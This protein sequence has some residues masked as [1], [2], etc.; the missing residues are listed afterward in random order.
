MI[1]VTTFRDQARTW[2]AAT[3]P[4]LENGLDPFDSMTE[5][6]A[7]R[8]AKWLQHTLFDGGFAGIVFP[9]EYGGRGLTPAH[10]QAFTAEANGYQSP[11]RFNMSTVAIIAPAILEFGTEEQKRRWLPEILRGDTF[12]AQLLSE[13]TG[14][15]DLAGARTRATRDGDLWI[16]NGSKVWTTGG[17]LRDM[18]LCLARTDW[19]VPKHKGLSFFAV[20]LHEPGVEVRRI[21]Q[22]DGNAD[23]CQEFFTDVALPADRLVG[24]PGQGWPIAQRLLHFERSAV[25]GS[26]PYAGRITGRRAGGGSTRRQQ[27]L[28]QLAGRLGSSEEP[29][30]RA[31]VAEAHVIATV[32]AHL[33]KRLQVGT[34][35]GTLP[36]ATAAA[37]K[38]FT[39]ETAAR[40]TSIGVELAGTESVVGDDPALGALAFGTEYLVRQAR[41]IA[42][43]SSEIQRNNISERV[44]GMPRERAEDTDR[45]FAEVQLGRVPSGRGGGPG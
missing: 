35:A 42:G 17:H 12:W 22:A 29:E 10:Q 11:L 31:L 27:N 19:D 44:L 36:A 4:S 39:A 13:P 34:R 16:L 33:I 45:P 40:I 41:C 14:G 15:S 8:H 20:D 24:D 23:F 26:T 9:E 38:L 28:V 18:G 21:R 43:G 2:L 6:Q 1:D 37:L 3:M 30:A 32:R 25:G 5:L 7:V